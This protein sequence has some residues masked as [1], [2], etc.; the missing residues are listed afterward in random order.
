MTL[1]DVEF[2]AHGEHI[3]ARL[4]GELDLSNAEGIGASVA[5]MASNH[6]AGLILDLS[7]LDYL[8]SAGI[9]LVYRLREQ[10]RVR[11]Q[12]LALV[13]PPQSP[14]ADALRLGGVTLH[15]PVHARLR[16][17]LAASNVR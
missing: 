11:S 9:H 16:D 6:A 10:L 5:D 13:I 14:A 4:T 1:G 3:V 12:S 15:V 7:A 8:D 17:A 2:S